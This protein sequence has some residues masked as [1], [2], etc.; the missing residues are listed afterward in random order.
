MPAL[1]LLA[2]LTDFGLADGYVGVMK[3]V[4]LGIHL[5]LQIVDVTHDV[6]PQDIRTGAWILATA[7]RFFPPGTVFLAVVDPGV[8]TSRHPVA[9][10]AGE[11]FFVGPDNGI[12]SFVL[13][14]APA[15]RSF[16]L[17]NPTYH[18]PDPA[19]PSATFHGRDVFAPCAAH[20]AAGVPLEALGSPVPPATLA[21]LPLPR[22]AW[23]GDLLRAHVLHVDR[24]GNL[25]TDVGPA[26]A[27]SILKAPPTAVLLGGYRVVS[28]AKTFGE[29][30]VGEPFLLRDSSG[31][32]A[33]A[34]QDGSAAALLGAS[35]DDEVLIRGL[36][37]TEAQT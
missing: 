15:T 18:R 33:I 17:D 12:F 25:I 31:H 29:G 37:R 20:L 30:P 16:A 10:E 9:I 6:P 27:D 13:A 14:E 26:L 2:L 4:A 5:N 36:T 32:L 8:G 23:D 35:R 24:F 19:G 21:A 7:W 28:R 22:L 34:V 3:G 1:P 11:R